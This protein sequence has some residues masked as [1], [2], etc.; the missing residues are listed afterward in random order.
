MLHLDHIAALPIYVARRRLMRMPEPTI[1][2]PE[3]AV[4]DVRSLLHIFQR[5]DRG[6][7][8]CQL[9]GCKPGDEFDLSRELVLSAFATHHTVPSLGFI[10][11]DAAKEAQRGVPS[12]LPG[13]TDPRP[14][15]FPA[16]KSPLRFAHRWLPIWAT[17]IPALDEHE[18]LFRAKIL[19]LEMTFVAPDHRKE[20]I[21]KFGHIHIDDIV[22][23]ASRFENELIIASH[24]STPLSR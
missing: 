14:S 20:H 10:V 15:V 12:A 1:Y 2:L 4:A 3:T 6:R 21:H 8:P 17:A 5:L 7:L 19:I 22:K 24:F 23:R 18:P 13:E 11:W 16:A 9:I